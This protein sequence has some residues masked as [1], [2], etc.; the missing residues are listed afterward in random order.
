MAA[1]AGTR[2][3]ET[4]PV[5]RLDPVIVSASPIMA[6]ENPGRY[7]GTVSRVDAVQIESMGAIDLPT[8][9]RRVPGVSISRFNSLGAFGGADGGA[10]YIRGQGAGRP[11]SE[12]MVYQDGAPREVGVWAHPLMDTTPIDFA[13]R[14]DV[15]KGP[16]PA[17][18]GG[19]LGAI[20]IS[21]PRVD[22]T[23]HHPKLHLSAG[24][25]ATR[26]GRL[27][28]GGYA[29]GWDYF[30]GLSI[31]HSDGHRPH[32]AARL[33]SS[34][35]RVG[36][37][38]DER[39][40]LAYIFQQT[41]NWVEDPGRVGMPTP[42]R[43]R[44]ASETWT[45]I[46]RLDDIENPDLPG[47]L[48]GY[49]EDGRIRWDQ[50]Q[51]GG[52]GTPPGQSATDWRNYGWRMAADLARGKWVLTPGLDGKWEG[53]ESRT[54]TVTGQTPFAFDGR[55][56]TISPILSGRLEQRVGAFRITPSAGLRYD[57]HSHF[58][59]EWAPH[60]ALRFETE[61]WTHAL[62][63]ARGV[64]YP[65]V[66]AI[67]VSAETIEP[68]AAETVNHLALSTYCTFSPRLNTSLSVFRDEGNNRLVRTS[69]GLVNAGRMNLSGVEGTLQANP[70]DWLSAFA[71]LTWLVPDDS[72]AVR[73][74]AYSLSAGFICRLFPDWTL[75]MDLDW[76]DDQYTLNARTPESQRQAAEKIKGFTLVNARLAYALP[77]ILPAEGA[78][79]VAV[80]NLT[81]ARY[82]YLP[83]YPMPG[84]SYQFGLRLSL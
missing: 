41:D 75:S 84:R 10:L 26:M 35:A 4:N 30:G 62:S 81:E 22:Q 42:D 79:Y 64:H 67:G 6:V 38:I 39:W 65:G 83:G 7:G 8:A 50:D 14:I 49:F 11:G 57:S 82:A 66:Y 74:P 40:R 5:L 59:D 2:K 18:H 48:I 69:D 27:S 43:E 76:V 45:H 78:L 28:L 68:M 51:V 29:K 17:T 13:S 3:G 60:A 56:H 20:A 73:A 46:V 80:E 70:A 21:G 34:Y 31:K 77:A 15:F 63:F 47:F 1:V 23:G 36:V 24:S 44:F 37:K 32:A 58:D 55:Y 12:I 72:R 19:T 16:Q 53:G 9:L 25:H 61:S 52:P 33:W 54:R 71:G